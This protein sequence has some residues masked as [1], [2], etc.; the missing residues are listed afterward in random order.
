MSGAEPIIIYLVVF[1]MVAGLI[2]FI[3]FRLI[4]KHNNFQSDSNSQPAAKNPYPPILERRDL[5][6]VTRQ[7]RAVMRGSF[8]KRR[9][10]NVSED[11]VF[12]IIENDIRNARKDFRVFPQVSLGE[13]LNSHNRAA[14][15]A[16]NN[17]RVDFLIVDD[18]RLPVAVI[19]YQGGGHFQGTAEARDAIKFEALRKAD[20]GYIEIFENENAEQICTRVRERLGWEIKEPSQIKTTAPDPA[21]PQPSFGH[22]ARAS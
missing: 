16:I 14:F 12:Q 3:G 20:I 1:V 18:A 21:E 4:E 8:Q 10:L 7:L 2:A 6:L 9:I 5:A 15:F 22:R 17:K 13:I 19:E 11:R